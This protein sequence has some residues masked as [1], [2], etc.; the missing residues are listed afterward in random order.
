[1]K[2]ISMN[3]EEARAELRKICKPGDTLHTIL[4]HVSRSGM[5]RRISVI[6]IEKD[7]SHVDLDW[8]VEKA[9]IAKS[10]RDK[11]GL[12]M[13]GCGMDMGFA[14]VYS[15]SSSLYRGS[16]HCIGKG[17]PANDHNNG[18]R[19]YEPHLHS[20]GGYALRQSWI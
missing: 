17:C 6:K 16:F 5:S 13:G 10:R 19:N 1:V 18:D 8:L 7:G 20:D 11:R 14:L 9:G 15:I 2:E 3:K 12:M 4:R